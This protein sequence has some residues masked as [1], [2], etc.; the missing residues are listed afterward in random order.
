MDLTAF[1]AEVGT[2]DPVTIAGLGTRDGAVAGV[3]CVSAPSGIEWIQA[4][5]MTVSCGAGTPVD[6]LSAALAEVGQRTVLPAGGTVGGAL[7]VGRSGIRRLGDGAVRDVLLQTHY[8]GADGVV[9]KAGGPTVKNVSGFDVCRL[10]VG[11]QGTIG[12]LGD[13]I[14]RTRPIAPH[15][16]WF[17]AATD[18]PMAV[19]AA[20]HRP[21]AVLWDGISVHVLLEGHHLDVAEQATRTGLVASDG[22]PTLPGGRHAV[23]PADVLAVTSGLRPGAFVAE[24][25]MGI[26]RADADAIPPTP[27]DPGVAAISRRVKEG[28]DPTGRLNPGRTA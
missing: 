13:V 12:F 3:R 2:D 19:F 20:V 6:E 4:D 22:P 28:F 25:G 24:L 16:A 8:V 9:V 26:V 17:T 1:A 10:L 18:D 15:S 7:A 5:E 27:V 21:V 14:L 23:R 11:S